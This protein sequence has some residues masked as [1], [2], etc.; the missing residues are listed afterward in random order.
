MHALHRYA[1]HKIGTLLAVTKKLIGKL[2]TSPQH[3]PDL[4]WLLSRACCCGCLQ[5]TSC[6]NIPAKKHA[7]RTPPHSVRR[8]AIDASKFPFATSS[9]K[10]TVENDAAADRPAHSPVQCSVLCQIT[11]P[12][13]HSLQGASRAAAMSAALRPIFRRTPRLRRLSR[14]PGML[15]MA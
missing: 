3:N 12:Q 2:P 8:E 10:M 11:E 13:Q 6:A 14:G 5:A 4:V 9:H 1:Q 15:A 7:V